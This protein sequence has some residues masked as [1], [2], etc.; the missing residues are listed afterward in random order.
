[1]CSFYEWDWP[2]GRN[3][4]FP[5]V[6][7]FL[8]VRSF[9]RVW[10][11]I[12]GVPQNPWIL[13]SLLRDLLWIGHREWEKIIL[14]IACFASSISIISGSISFV[15]L[16]NCLYLN[17]RVL[18]FV[19]SLPS[20]TGG[21]GMGKLSGAELLAA[22]LNHN[23]FRRFK[24]QEEVKQTHVWMCKGIFAVATFF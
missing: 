23:N 18:S 22:R 9:P 11:F 3:P 24:A 20:P 13:R 10:T 2:G 17:P 6:W 1:M 16:L 15:V 5:R 12:L 14:S 19:H 7:T 8:W 21:K 4:L